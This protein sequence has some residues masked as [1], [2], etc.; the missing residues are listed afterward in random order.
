MRE[1][2]EY[3]DTRLWSAVEDTISELMAT[4]ELAV[5]TAPEYVVGYICRELVAKKVVTA[6]ALERRA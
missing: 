5:D 3:R 2:D 4:R 6:S 1:F